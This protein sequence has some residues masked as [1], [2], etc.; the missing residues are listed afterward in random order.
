MQAG[1]HTHCVP[2]HLLVRELP[3]LGELTAL[4]TAGH[5]SLDLWADLYSDSNAAA[6]VTAYCC[7]LLQPCSQDGQVVAEAAWLPRRAPV[8][9][10]R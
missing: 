4:Y 1:T 6:P 8:R 3:W 10:Q 5:L 9:V 7:V 2:Q